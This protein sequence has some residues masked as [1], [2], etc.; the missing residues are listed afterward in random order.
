MPPEFATRRHALSVSQVGQIKKGRTIGTSLYCFCERKTI[1]YLTGAYIVGF[2]QKEVLLYG[3]DRIGEYRPDSLL[4]DQEVEISEHP[5][6]LARR[7]PRLTAPR[8]IS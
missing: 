7:I 8:R 5:A 6:M 3:S 1:G 4:W 2:Y